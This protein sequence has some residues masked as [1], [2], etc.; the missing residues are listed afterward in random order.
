[1]FCAAIGRL[2]KTLITQIEM[3]PVFFLQSYKSMI[4]FNFSYSRSVDLKE[5]LDGS[6]H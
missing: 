2:V 3:Q 4:F 5:E 6:A 1:M